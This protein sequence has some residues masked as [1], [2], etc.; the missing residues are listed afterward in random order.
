MHISKTQLPVELW[1]SII[2]GLPIIDQ[3]TCLS[4]CRTWRKISITLLFDVV[5]LKLGTDA[6]DPFVDIDREF[7]G[8]SR[9]W[10]I[11]ER[12]T[13]DRTFALAVK[14][15]VVLALS[16]HTVYARRE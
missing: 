2:A 1:D 7:E 15:I 13:Q 3:K 16:D 5:F 12:I 10:E 8:L 14:K 6:H 9:S 11:M 4:V